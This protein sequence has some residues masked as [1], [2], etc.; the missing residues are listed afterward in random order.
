[1]RTALHARNFEGNALIVANVVAERVAFL[2]IAD[3]FIHTPLCGTG[4]QRCDGNAP[5]IQDGQEVR[6]AAAALT[7]QVFFGHTGVAECQ[8]VGV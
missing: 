7:E 1:M 8:R 2:G 5:L 4:G 3:G 6:V